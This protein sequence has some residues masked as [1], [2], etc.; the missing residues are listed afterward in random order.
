MLINILVYNWTSPDLSPQVPV[1]AEIQG[2]SLTGNFHHTY[3]YFDYRNHIWDAD[4]VFDVSIQG[5]IC[6]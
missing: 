4:S 2:L 6:V 5:Y 1:M 3:E